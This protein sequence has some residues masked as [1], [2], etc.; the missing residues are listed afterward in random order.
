MPFQVEHQVEIP[1]GPFLRA[2]LTKLEVA[3]IPYTDRKTGERKEFSKLNWVFEIIEQGD[4]TGK[5]VRGESSAFLSDAPHNRFRNWAEALL[6][7]PLDLG[8]VLNESDLEGLTAYITVKYE[9]D[10]ND[11]SKRWA[12][13]D[14]VIPLDPGAGGDEPPF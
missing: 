8:Q 13:V 12:R 14:D 1:E 10:K 5:S 6:Q 3:T 11:S 9:V 7:R 2:K 4:F